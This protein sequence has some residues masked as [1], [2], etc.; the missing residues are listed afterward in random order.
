MS[1]ISTKEIVEPVMKDL[2]KQATTYMGFAHVLYL[3]DVVDKSP[4]Y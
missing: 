2:Y 3:R 1:K 4:R